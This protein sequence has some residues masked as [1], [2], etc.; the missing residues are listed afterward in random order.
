MKK[1]SVLEEK[2]LLTLLESA[3]RPLHLD[4]ILRM[5]RYSRRIKREVL[6][7]L[8]TLGETGSALRLRGGGWLASASVKTCRG[9]FSAQR[10]GAGFVTPQG[11]AAADVYVAPEHAGGAW[12]GDL[13]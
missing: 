3:N 10:S 7:A 1:N 12:N 8:Q 4:D 6:A 2:D 11:D 13:V 9:R 5:G